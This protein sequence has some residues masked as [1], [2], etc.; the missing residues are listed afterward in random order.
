MNLFELFFKIGVDD[1]ASGPIGMLTDKLGGGLKTAAKIG[2]DAVAVAATGIAALTKGAIENYAEYEQLVGGVDTLF[3]EASF[4][5]QEYAANAFQT[6]GLSAN[7]YMDTVTSFS[8]SLLQSLGGNTKMAAAV[9]DQA[10]VDM[11]DNAN[12]M[13]TDISMIQNAYQGFAKQNY[14]MLDN[15]KLGYGGTKKEMERLIADANAVK[16]ANGEMGDLSIESFADIVEAIH[17]IQTEMDISGISIEE[18][19]ELVSSGAMSQAEAFELLGTTAKEASSTIAGSTASMKAAWSNLL[20]GIA[21][22]NQNFDVLID[23]FVSS[24]GTV[25]QNILPRIEVALGGAAKLIDQMIPIIVERI[26]PLVESILPQLVSSAVKIVES[27]VTGISDNKEMLFTTAFD[28]IMVLADGVISMLPDIIA[29]G[30]ELIVALVE[31]IA[32]NLPELIP[33]AVAMIGEIYAILTNE[34]TARRLFDATVSILGAL[35][36]ALVE[37]LP[38]LIET[39]VDL[40]ISLANA[41]VK[42]EA[43]EYILEAALDII[44]ALVEGLSKAIPKLFEAAVNVIMALVEYVLDP[45][46]L[47]EL[48]EMA[49]EIIGAIVLGIEAAAY[50]LLTAVADLI[51]R[52]MQ[53]FE[54]TDWLEL[55]RN[56]IEGILEGLKNAWE[57]LK[58][59]FTSAVDGLV[60]GIKEM[61]GIHS[62]SRV[63]AEI[64][65]NMALGIGGGWG[66]AFAK[67]R[68]DIDEDMNIGEKAFA[69]RQTKGDHDVVSN[70]GR[71]TVN[72]TQNIYSRAMTAA[73]LM[74]E[75]MYEQERAVLMGV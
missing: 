58:E 33:A 52:L 67:I 20:T 44:Y 30:L 73:D 17:L 54:E 74:E 25:A 71:G 7:E 28:A 42:P 16:E 49:G 48:G 27:L 10:I 39:A 65:K 63:F 19:N 34:D 61:L 50:N 1:Q 53:K 35:V 72:V 59:W 32:D 6:A 36:K 21:D 62:P 26:P 51:H 68:D 43:I 23:N 57:N 40:V 37:N 47:R 31:G 41:L 8:A 24:V 75:A 55:G 45:D 11:S 46:N 9:A 12:K 15:L 69:I 13:G 14:T 22:D 66:D 5:V 3:K 64:G 18:Y 60:G 38:M 4:R 2:I 29:L 70:G 56:I